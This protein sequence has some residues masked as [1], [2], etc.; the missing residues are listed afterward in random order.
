[1]HSDIN[2]RHK[3]MKEYR[4]KNRIRIGEYYRKYRKI[5]R[6]RIS[7]LFKKRKN[8]DKLKVL[9]Y[10]SQNPPTCNCCGESHIEF[11]EIDHIGGEG[12][13]HRKSLKLVSGGVIFYRWIIRNN[14]P[15]LF[16]VL[17][18]NCNKALGNFGYCPHKKGENNAT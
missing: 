5:H 15:P 3:Y 1:M 9:I 2:V 7:E 16:R 6:L 11:L 4:R 14:Y 18:S 17:C 13:K 8:R 12:N 10:Y